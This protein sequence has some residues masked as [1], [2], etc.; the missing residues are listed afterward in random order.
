MQL[1][2]PT[3]PLKRLASLRTQAALFE[4]FRGIDRCL[5]RLRTEPDQ[6]VSMSAVTELYAHWGDPLTQGDESY[7]RS[8]LAEAARA[9]G[10]VVQ[11]G[12]SLMSLILGTVHQSNASSPPLWCLEHDAHW[13]NVVR[14]WLTQYQIGNVHVISSRAQMG[15]GYVWYGV[16]PGRLAKDIA[17]LICEGARATPRGVAGAL[18]RLGGRLADEFTVL[19]RQVSR[20]DD[21]R[22][23]ATWARSHDAAFVVV[24]RQQGFI[25][26]AR[27]RSS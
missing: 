12:A 4:R 27:R 23:F 14:S 3:A 10:P 26:I 1:P 25:K 17:L 16:D 15:D 18:Q 6:P 22:E 9:S 21:L 19:A 5:R 13:A 24:D 11:C 2:L 8:C 20:A 7:I